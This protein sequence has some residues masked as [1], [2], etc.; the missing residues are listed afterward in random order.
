MG[1]ALQNCWGD[2]SIRSDRFKWRESGTPIETNLIN[3]A[4][5]VT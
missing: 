4:Y 3:K 5:Q 2:G 1:I